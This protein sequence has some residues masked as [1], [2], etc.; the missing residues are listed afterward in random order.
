MTNGGARWA[1]PHA[2]VP[3]SFRGRKSASELWRCT[4]AFAANS[5]SLAHFA[6]TSLRLNNYWKNSS[7]IHDTQSSVIS[8]F[9]RVVKETIMRVSIF[10]LK[11]VDSKREI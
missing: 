11:G 9:P 8:V 3:R 2:G 4:T 10:E 6:S 5:R 1:M 7:Q